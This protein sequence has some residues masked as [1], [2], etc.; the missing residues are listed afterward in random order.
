MTENS[1][2]L[3]SD[4]NVGRSKGIQ[5]ETGKGVY[6]VL[7]DG[8]RVID[9]SNTGASL[10]HSHPDIVAAVKA[11]AEEP[12][13]NDGWFWP[14]REAAIDELIETAFDGDADRVGAVRFAI[15]GGEANDLAL[16]LAQALTGRS[17]L[18]TRERAYH[19]IC[20]LARE[21]TVQPHWHG[22]LSSVDGGIRP[23]ARLADVRQLPMPRGA[24]IK[25]G[26]EEMPLHE[27]RADAVGMMKDAAAVILDYT[28]GG[29]YHSAGYQDT[30]ASAAK[31]TGALWI[32]DEVVTGFGRT[33]TWFGFEGGEARPDIITLGKPLAGGAAPAGAVVLSKRVA[34]ML[35]HERWQTFST[36]RGHPIMVAAMR[37]HLKVHARDGLLDH[38]KDLDAVFSGRLAEMAERH[39]S[40]T[41][42][43]GRGIHWTI[44][45]DGPD[46][47]DW[48]A[49]VSEP[50]LAS[51]VANRALEAGALIGTS[52]EQTSL[53]LAPPFILEEEEAERLL[54]A[55]DQGLALA[56]EELERSTVASR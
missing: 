44:E 39:P 52:G 17:A 31:E 1:K 51:R 12:V 25:G 42:I 55:L 21:M 8:R 45:L 20:G 30:I 46:W 4:F 56:D 38:V 35:D 33:G 22:G 53:F 24:R 26:E 29:I 41:R 47:R 18:V 32:A 13:V 5:V 16:S 54:E 37:A 40:V 48:H 9:G 7:K 10:G 50:P 15:S 6:F 11:A 23:A 49:D 3:I 2:L 14:A 28:Q 27:L 19:G 43:D 36:F 34:E